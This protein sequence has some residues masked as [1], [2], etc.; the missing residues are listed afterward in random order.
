VKAS[1]VTT[2]K[3]DWQAVDLCRNRNTARMIVL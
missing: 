2:K 3:A 1:K